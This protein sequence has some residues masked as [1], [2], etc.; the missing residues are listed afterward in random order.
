MKAPIPE[1]FQGL[2]VVDS[3]RMRE[4][5]RLAVE[6]Y[7]LTSLELMENAG[8]AVAEE[9][10]QLLSGRFKQPIQEAL[11]TVCCGRGNNGGDGLVA[12]RR[13]KGMGAEVMVYIAPAKRDASY[14]A[15]FQKN[16]TRAVEAGVSIHEV[17]EELV[18][19]D[20][21]LRSS[22]MVIDA[23]LGTGASG[24]PAGAVHKMIQRITQAARPVLAVDIPSGLHPD[25]GYHSG[26]VVVAA[27][28]CALGLAKRGLLAAAAARYVGELKVLDIGFPKEL[29]KGGR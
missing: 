12:A 14:P 19:L 29:L 10:A 1:E 11:I 2:P 28:T 17:S 5:D 25:T 7:G 16:L 20:V 21:R 26:V 27:R 22:A 24:K 23:L 18:E 8:R 4:I 15:E 9:A 3:A 6:R 13:L